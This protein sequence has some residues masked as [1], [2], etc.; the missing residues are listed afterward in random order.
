MWNITPTND[1][2]EH[3]NDN[4]ICNPTLVLADN[5][6]ILCIHNSFDKREHYEKLHLIWYN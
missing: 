6:V 5:G 1:L 4:C 2:R 3:T